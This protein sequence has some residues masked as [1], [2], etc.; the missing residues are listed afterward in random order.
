MPSLSNALRLYL[1]IAIYYKQFLLYSCFTHAKL[2]RLC[3]CFDKP[4]KKLPSL[5][6]CVYS[7]Y[8]L[9]Y[10]RS[11]HSNLLLTP[12]RWLITT[13]IIGRS[14]LVVQVT[15]TS[16]TTASFLQFSIILDVLIIVV[17]WMPGQQ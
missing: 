13:T 4:L 6:Y 12:G 7:L 3:F 8:Q 2:L 9:L 14:S 17:A 15:V 11:F 5:K 10:T 16:N 1:T